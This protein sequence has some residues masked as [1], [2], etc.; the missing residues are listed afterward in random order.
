MVKAQGRDVFDVVPGDEGVE[1]MQVVFV[2][3]ADPAAEIHSFFK[4][5]KNRHVVPPNN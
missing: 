3:L 1:V 5:N 4:P 2:E